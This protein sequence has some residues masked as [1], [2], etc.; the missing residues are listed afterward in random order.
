MSDSKDL[1]DAERAEFHARM[2]N[3]NG[4]AKNRKPRLVEGHR[5]QWR[6]AHRLAASHARHLMFVR[7]V[8]W[9][10]WDGKRWAEDDRG[11]SKRAVGV[12][13]RAAL[14]EAVKLDASSRDELIADVRRCETANGVAGVLDLAAALEPFAFCVYDLDP[15]PWLLNCQNGTLDLRT[16]QIRPHDPADRITKITRAGYD[17]D[18]VSGEWDRFLERVLPDVEVR[19]YLQRL[20]GLSL[21]GKVVEHIFPVLTGSGGNGKGTTYAALLWMLGDYGHAAEMDLFMQA[22]TNPNQASPALMGLRG[23]RLVVASETEKAKRLA[24]ALMKH[25]TGG[26]PITTRPLYGK[27]VTFQP[28]HTV[29][30]VT[31]DPPKV[32]ADDLAVWRRIRVV[33]FTVKIT[34]EEM[35]GHLDTSLQLAADAVLAWAVEGYRQ[36]VANG[37][38]L[39][40]PSAVLHATTDYKIASDALAKFI[41]DMCTTGPHIHVGHRE[42][43]TA[44][45][46]WCADTGE[47]PGTEKEFGL[48]VEDKGYPAR[49]TNIG[50]RYG[51]LALETD[52][53]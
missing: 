48:A 50:K 43:F 33:P 4:R 37:D 7:G 28:S 44:W 53:E 19:G 32:P 8:G 14:A 9:H 30:M 36:Y 47:L 49:K 42:L 35:D 51:R 16:M 22:K 41:S 20:V 29:L 21:L 1:T 45:R 12:V 38:R 15:D 27:P 25:L 46:A 17:A 18:A 24:V 52:P 40:E 13:L 2:D 10:H 39:N 11:E 5:G 3:P 23:K 6:I 34:D 31:N 26:D